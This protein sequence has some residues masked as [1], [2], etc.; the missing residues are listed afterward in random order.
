M[1]FSGFCL[2]ERVMKLFYRILFGFCLSIGLV[3]IGT[4]AAH[5]AAT[6]LGVYHYAQEKPNWCWVA[7]AKSAIVHGKP[8]VPTQCNVYKLAKGGSTCPD[9]V[10]S[11]ADV[12]TALYGSGFYYGG[13]YLGSQVTYA[14]IQSDINL[15][16]PIPLRWGWNS[17]GG[18]TG[19]MVIIY[20]FN[21]VNSQVFFHD[22]ALGG[23]QVNSYSW[24]QSG[25]GHTWTH[26]LVG[27]TA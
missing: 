13:N 3:G 1:A 8:G 12:R 7:V 16:K 11:L 26:T 14:A 4:S 17:T 5:A 22:P 23:Y 27:I 10:G 18:S 20:A 21:T 24:L 19:H 6:Y 9:G 25:G 15:G 2:L